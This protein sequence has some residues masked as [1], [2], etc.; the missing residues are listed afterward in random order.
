MLTSG[1][2]GQWLKLAMMNEW[3]NGWVHE[4][5]DLRVRVVTGNAARSVYTDAKRTVLE[6][7]T[8]CGPRRLQGSVCAAQAMQ[9]VYI[10]I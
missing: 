2:V 3:M 9:C 7:S 8:D 1:L 4:S 5:I 10:Y 6:V